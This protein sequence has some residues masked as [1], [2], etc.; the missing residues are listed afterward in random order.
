MPALEVLELRGLCN[1]CPWRGGA[2]F[3]S[4]AFVLK[5][6]R[7]LCRRFCPHFLVE[8]GLWTK[9]HQDLFF[10]GE[11][12][13][14]NKHR[15]NPNPHENSLHWDW[16]YT[17]T[18]SQQTQT[19]AHTH[20]HTHTHAKTYTHPDR[21]THALTTRVT[22]WCIGAVTREIRTSAATESCARHRLAV[23]S[24]TR[25]ESRVRSAITF[26]LSLV[27]DFL[28]FVLRVEVNNGLHEPGP[29]PLVRCSPNSYQ[30]QKHDGTC[31]PVTSSQ[32]MRGA[33][34]TSPWCIRPDE[35]K[36]PQE[37]TIRKPQSCIK[38]V[39]YRET[40]GRDGVF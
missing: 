18:S 30:D 13:A 17:H 1:I 24:P 26:F 32:F 31:T 28:D 9:L 6:F 25:R 40:N 12:T 36:W 29:G 19:W 8:V 22:R 3:N 4:F 21:C 34:Y 11:R 33:Y 16:E 2:W 5:T 7:G 27:L 38:R 35:Y 37:K 15:P 14:K 20:T 10:L 39:V 23:T